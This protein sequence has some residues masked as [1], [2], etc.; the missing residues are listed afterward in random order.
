M[1]IYYQV[2]SSAEIWP[3]FWFKSYGKNVFVFFKPSWLPQGSKLLH[4]KDRTR[5]FPSCHTIMINHQA[6]RVCPYPCA[7]Q[8]TVPLSTWIPCS[9]KGFWC[10]NEGG[11]KFLKICP[12]NDIYLP[13]CLE[14]FCFDQFCC[15]W[16]FLINRIKANQKQEF[17]ITSLTK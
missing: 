3:V 1:I 17:R 12:T 8:K 7:P 9:P 4:P 13:T 14:E 10:V 6:A 11:D 5:T 15:D 2:K 16:K